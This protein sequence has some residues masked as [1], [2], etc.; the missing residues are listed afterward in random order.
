M[1]VSK[2]DS[3]AGEEL[4]SQKQTSVVPLLEEIK[5]TPWLETVTV[6]MGNSD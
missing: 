2:L 6:L 4:M 1:E 5:I 3:F